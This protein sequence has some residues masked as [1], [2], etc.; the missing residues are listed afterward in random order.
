MDPQLPEYSDILSGHLQSKS[1]RYIWGFFKGLSM[2]RKFN[3]LQ[4]TQNDIGILENSGRIINLFNQLGYN[5]SDSTKVD[6]T[7]LNITSDDLKLQINAIYKV[8]TDPDDEEIEI[9]LFEVRSV[10]V[11]LTQATSRQFRTRGGSNLLIFTSEY[12][13]LDFVLIDRE[14]IQGRTGPRIV[15]RPRH[16]TVNRRNPDPVALRVLKRFTFTE[17]DSLY[18]WEKLLGAYT[19][20]EW[21]EPNFNNRA[22]FSDYYL[23]QRLTDERLTPEWG[24]DVRPIGRKIMGYFSDVRDRLTGKPE[25]VI[26]NQLI[27]PIFRDLG[28]EFVGNKSGVLEPDEPDYRLYSPGNKDKPFALAL[29]YV[30]NRNLDIS[31]PKRDKESPEENPGARVVSLLEKGEAPWVIMTN[32]KIWRLYSATASNKATNYYEI[33]LEEALVA[34]D[35]VTALKY[36]WL[37]FRVEAFVDFLDKVLFESADYAK[38]LGNR[39][40]NSVF[41]EIFPHFAYGFISDMRVNGKA[42]AEIDLSAVFN[43]TMTF[44]YRLMF[45][46]YAESLELV[47]IN[48]ESGYRQQSVYRLKNELANIVG[49]VECQASEKIKKAYTAKSTQIYKDHLLPLFHVIDLGSNAI[50][51]PTYN[52]GLFS[53]QTETGKFLEQYA[54]PDKQLSLGMDHLCRALDE[55]TQGLAMIDFKSLGVRQL[56]SIYEGLLEFKLKIAEEKLAV[57]KESGKEVF[58]PFKEAEKKNKRVLATI[59]KGEVYLENDKRERKATGSYYTPDYIV[60]YIVEHTVSPVLER[61]FEVLS[62]RLRAA[63][64]EYRRHKK[65]A[66]QKKENPEKFWNYKDMRQLA[67]DCLNIRLLDPAMGSGHFLVEAVDFI[68]IKLINF[69]NAWSDNPVWAMLEQ[70]RDDI[71]VEM[72]RQGVAVDPDRLTRVALLKRSVLKRCIYGVDLNPMAVELAKVSLWL[73]AFTLG[74]PLSF[75]DHHLKIGNSL[76][77]ARIKEVQ[78]Y[79]NT[80]Y[81]DQFDMFSGNEFAGVMLATDL[82]QKVSYMSDNTVSQV[83]ASQE[84]FRNASDQLSPYKRLLDVYTSKWFSN[85]PEQLANNQNSKKKNKTDLIKLFL[86]QDD[87]KNWLRDPVTL[88]DDRLFPASTIGENSENDVVDNKFFHWELAFPEVYFAPSKP[89]GQDIGLIK[90]RG[91]DVVVGNPP[92]AAISGDTL[93]NYYKENY[94]SPEYQY[95][96]Y[97]LFI[98]ASV[99]L[100]TDN[101]H[102]GMIVPTTFLVE[103]Y[104]S[105][106]RNYL[107]ENTSLNKILH[108]KFSVFDDATVESAIYILSREIQLN[109]YIEVGFVNNLTLGNIN[110]EIVDQIVYENLPGK[111]LNVAVSGKRAG[112]IKKLLSEKYKNLGSIANI[113]VGIKPYQVGKGQPKQNRSDVDNRIYDAD[114]KLNETYRQYLVGSNINRYEINPDN[115]N[116]ISYGDWLAEPRYSAPFEATEKLLVRQTG[117]SIISAV[118]SSQHITLNNLHNLKL[119]NDRLSHLYLSAILNSK[120]IDFFYKIIVPEEGRVFAEVK[121]VDLEYFPLPIIESPIDK[122]FESLSEKLIQFYKNENINQILRLIPKVGD[123]IIY[124]L[125]VYLSQRMMELNTDKDKIETEFLCFLEDELETRIDDLAGKTIIRNFVG[126][127]RIDENFLPWDEVYYRLSQNKR[128]FKSNLDQIKGKLFEKYTKTITN[129]EPIKSTLKLTDNLIDK[130]VYTHYELSDDE[131][132]LVERPYYEQRIHE[133]KAKVQSDE[134]LREDL[135]AAFKYVSDQIEPATVRFA[136]ISPPRKAETYLDIALPN[137]RKLSDRVQILLS[138]AERDFLDTD[139]FDYTG[140]EINYAKSVEITIIEYLFIPFREGGFTEDDV[141]NERAFKRF[142]KNE[143]VLTLGNFPF[144]F[145][146]KEQKFREFIAEKYADADIRIFS[147]EGILGFLSEEQIQSRNK[148]AHED[149]VDRGRAGKAREWAFSILRNLA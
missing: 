70:I 87:V 19:L 75:L 135:D 34:P 109:N 66:E 101:G 138:S 88:L 119:K 140:S 123:Q 46:L 2:D 10:T 113:T 129:L 77:G 48:E 73:D 105:K 39:L 26:R 32:G 57:V 29:A 102:S 121:T 103:H 117:D 21:S 51:L 68:S 25:A 45:L 64:H 71:L 38:E 58:L 27:E 30:W 17:A 111:D 143:G 120:L 76:I 104:Y 125:L 44:L 59:K 107:L 134:N 132:E 141:Y 131:I 145:S 72:E 126:D 122:D 89:D 8:G 106:V 54:I 69:L 79:L 47:P 56:G 98:E 114:N 80:G 92:Y 136:E 63:Q 42:D 133:A 130:V 22:L 91:F 9:Y 86:K 23:N 78:D 149:I 7:L 60:K 85:T 41:E 5:V 146:S 20:A 118:D 33:D 31:D 16:L 97:I 108:F 110:Y 93:R 50:N 94:E 1:S 82:M 96:A 83:E 40:K 18:Q 43:G 35:Q 52:G 99:S 62:D 14:V 115:K 139:R 28:F 49:A 15:I 147:K 124:D 61:K 12:E 137:W 142:M 112:L 90:G 74:A 36:W 53:T 84:A 127:Y 95:D 55:K 65:V 148:S 11:A 67:D 100:C 3:D 116:W 128:Y 81:G 37:L 24:E 144:L 13:D 4:L 6:P